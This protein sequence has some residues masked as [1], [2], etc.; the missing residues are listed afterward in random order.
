MTASAPSSPARLWF[1]R[2]FALTLLLLLGWGSVQLWMARQQAA[3][4]ARIHTLTTAGVLQRIQKLNHLESMAFHVETVVTSE[5]QGNWYRLWQDHQKGL[6]IARGRVV[7][8]LD[9]S[10]LTPAQVQ[11]SADGQRV[12][13]QL[14]PVRILSTGIE[15]MDVYD[16]ETGLYGLAQVDPNL[17]NDAQT[18][19]HTQVLRSACAANILGLATLQAQQQVSQL[20]ALLPGVQV[21]VQAGD[22]PRQCP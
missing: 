8:G 10:R 1:W 19:A 12:Q 16:L 7:A 14:P 20:F 15:R 21:Q 9:L 5:K 18:A 17:L 4:Q 11:V 22:V 2:G 13:I 3:E 6:F